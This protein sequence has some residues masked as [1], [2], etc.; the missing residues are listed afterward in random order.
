MKTRWAWCGLL[1]PSFP[2]PT[3]VSSPQ[4]LLGKRNPYA[5]RV[6]QKLTTLLEKLFRVQGEELWLDWIFA[7][8]ILDGLITAGCSGFFETVSSQGPTHRDLIDH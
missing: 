7:L 8:V 2:L 3:A 1:L 6:C 5:D 4:P